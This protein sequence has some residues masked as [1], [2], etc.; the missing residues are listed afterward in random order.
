VFISTASDFIAASIRHD[1]DFLASFAP[2]R[3]A[4]A[5]AREWA[6]RAAAAKD[7]VGRFSPHYEGSPIICG[8]GVPSAVGEHS[9]RARAGQHLAP[10]LLSSGRNSYALLDGGFTLFT[11]DRASAIS[12]QAAANALAVPLK[13]VTGTVPAYEAAHVLVRPDQFVAWAGDEAPIP[14]A[15]LR[16]ATGHTL[17][18]TAT[19]SPP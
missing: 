17:D 15:V 1:R 16:R 7:E 11:T 19:P 6:A 13:V 10:G 18:P 4:A 3:D 14:D 2:G 12:W 5:F 9:H 8:D